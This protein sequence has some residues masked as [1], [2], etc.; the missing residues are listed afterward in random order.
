MTIAEQ[1]FEQARQLPEPLAREALDFVLFL[2]T[3]HER[4]EW[5]DLMDAQSSALA[6]TWDNDA[7]EAWNNV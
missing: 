3:R 2:R 5:R 4:R 6:G 1:I 7:D